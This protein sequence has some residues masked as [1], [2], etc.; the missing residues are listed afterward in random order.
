[1]QP[2]FK[3]EPTRNLADFER[4]GVMLLNPWKEAC[5]V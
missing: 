5:L 3:K 2:F 1:M 4:T